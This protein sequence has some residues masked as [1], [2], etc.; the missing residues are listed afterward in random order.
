MPS[1]TTEDVKHEIETEREALGDAVD[2]LRGQALRVRRKLPFVAAGVAALAVVA[3][4]VRRRVSRHHA[5]ET[6]GRARF[7]RHRD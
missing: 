4:L 2:T 6:K 7:S 3:G 5:P 1:R